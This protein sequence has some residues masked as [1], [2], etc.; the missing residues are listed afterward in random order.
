MTRLDK[1]RARL[2]AATRGPWSECG[3][4]RG[5]CE[6]RQVSSSDGLV[7]LAVAHTDDEGLTGGEGY[8]VDQ[9]KRN[10]T[11]IA[12]APTDIAVL[13]RVAE[14]AAAFDA[15]VPE[16]G[17]GPPRDALRR[18]LAPLLAEVPDAHE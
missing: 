7:A 18:A 11:L 5:G 3:A 12:N 1:I 10:A 14:A 6:C 16:V 9:A 15:D 17:D 8:T 4:E 13:L 2:E